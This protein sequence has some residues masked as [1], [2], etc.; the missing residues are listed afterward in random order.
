MMMQRNRDVVPD[1]DCWWK[2]NTAVGARYRTEAH[3]RKFLSQ[4][5]NS[6]RLGSD[7]QSFYAMLDRLFPDGPAEVTLSYFPT[8][9]EGY[10][11]QD[12]MK[13]FCF[14]TSKTPLHTMMNKE[15]LRDIFINC[16]ILHHLKRIRITD[17]E[18]LPLD[19][20]SCSQNSSCKFLTKTKDGR[21]LVYQ[22]KN[23][24]LLFFKDSGLAYVLFGA[25]GMLGEFGMEERLEGVVY[26]V[27][28]TSGEIPA[29]CGLH[30]INYW[31]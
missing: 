30:E 19:L 17:D 2:T 5:K 1:F 23:C 9:F 29:I 31:R 4:W 3:R 6:S 18:T 20:T 16:R 7:A 11:Y 26:G 8:G 13:M 21:N 14:T 25:F 28:K 12:E 22:Y 10:I 24:A 27:Q 15:D